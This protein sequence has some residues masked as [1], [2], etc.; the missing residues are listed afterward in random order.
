M[1]LNET[2]S[3]NRIH[4]GF[5]GKRNAGKSSLVNAVTAQSLAV[6]SDV[7]GTTTDPV[8]KAMELLPLGPVMIIDTPGIDDEGGLGE[9][10]I[11]KAKQVLNKTDIAIL[12]VDATEGMADT[13]LDLVNTFISKEIPYLIAYNKSDL[14]GN[15]PAKK[16]NEIYVSAQELTGIYEL[17]EKI[18]HSV[19]IDDE[20]LKIVADLL[21]P[22]DFVVLVT[23]IDKAA[24]KGRLILP[25][26]QTIRDILEADATAIV[27]KEY[28]LRETLENLGK[29]PA[30]IITDSQVFAKVSAD[31]PSNIPL[32]SF[33]ILM[34]RYKGLLDTAVKGVVAVEELKDGDTVLISEGCSHHRQCDDIGTVKIPRWIKNYTGKNIN[35]QF[36]SGT[37]FPENLSPYK[38]IIHCGGCM[39]NE[40]EVRY[41]MKCAV[42]QGVPIT[43]YGVTIAYMQGILKRSLKIFPHLEAVLDELG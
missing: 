12:V 6:V 39:L 32:T 42:D 14:L 11:K 40:R 8:Y 36:T 43:N 9:L 2:P 15:L 41:R 28:E 29:E 25:Q 26:Q 7:K 30:M 37:E 24:P 10:R 33:S 38:M 17:K 18:A 21:H 31:A 20:K 35:F 27:V 1:G 4:I 23:P 16:P 19:Q 5:F 13:D 3:A 22:S 34:A